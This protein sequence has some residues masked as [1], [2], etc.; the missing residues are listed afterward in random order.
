MENKYKEKIKK[1]HKGGRNRLIATLF[2][3]ANGI[4]TSED[5]MKVANLTPRKN[6]TKHRYKLMI[7]FL[8][9]LGIIKRHF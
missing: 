7:L 5:I 3:E 6:R 2:M 4:V 9:S 8:A 1:M